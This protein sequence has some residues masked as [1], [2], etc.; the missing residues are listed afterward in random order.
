MSSESLPI[1]SFNNYLLNTYIILVSIYK[2]NLSID[3]FSS[4]YYCTTLWNSSPSTFWNKDTQKLFFYLSNKFI[5]SA[6][7]V[8]FYLLISPASYQYSCQ[9]CFSFITSTYAKHCVH[10]ISPSLLPR[11]S[12][13][14][15][16]K[17][18]FPFKYTILNIVTAQILIHFL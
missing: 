17:N 18:N 5:L 15:P 14:P 8:H 6:K 11:F 7:I 16:T 3:L 4:N 1:H 2:G 10:E 13:K 12:I 9:K